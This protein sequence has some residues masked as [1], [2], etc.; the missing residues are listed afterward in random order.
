MFRIGLAVSLL[1]SSCVS[2][3]ER[4]VFRPKDRSGAERPALAIWDGE[5][6]RASEGVLSHSIESLGGQDIAISRV[7]VQKI[8]MEYVAPEGKNRFVIG[9]TGED[10]PLI[11]FCG[12]T[13]FDRVRYGYRVMTGLL[14][15][16]D[17]VVWDYPGYGD[18]PGEPS[19]TGLRALTP[20]IAD[21]IDAQ[22]GE[23][24]L[25]LWGHSMGG[26]VCSDIARQSEAVDLLVLE[27]S[28]DRGAASAKSAVRAVLPFVPIR[29]SEEVAAI[30]VG[31]T[32]NGLDIPVLVLIAGDDE[33]IAPQI[34]RKLAARI[35]AME[36][37]AL[38]PGDRRAVV[39]FEDFGHDEILGSF[40]PALRVG[41]FYKH[42]GW[43][44]KIIPLEGAVTE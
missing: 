7:S 43:P 31:A 6:Y 8:E 26:A 14:P 30:D 9:A 42:L 38:S 3:S 21:W 17:P 5:S 39:E 13:A 28:L 25:I 40:L 23:R 32:V 22:A 15:M 27:A 20:A 29:V 12:G 19:I 10:R 33:V 34:Q 36:M 4:N 1:L 24:R 11:L 2:V 18:S 37:D 41:Q 35:G 16:G 44:S